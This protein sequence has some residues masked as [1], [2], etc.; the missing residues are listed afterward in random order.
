M[1]FQNR[2]C[3]LKIKKPKKNNNNIY[4]IEQA[5]KQPSKTP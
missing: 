2:P 5:C 3:F 4:R 1:I